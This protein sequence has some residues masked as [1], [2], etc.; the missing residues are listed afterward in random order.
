MACLLRSRTFKFHEGQQFKTLGP[1]DIC[2]AVNF[3]VPESVEMHASSLGHQFF[4][5]CFE[6]T[7]PRGWP[8]DRMFEFYGGQLS[9]TLGLLCVMSVH[10]FHGPIISRDTYNPTL[11][12]Q[13][14]KDKKMFEPT[15]ML[16]SCCFFFGYILTDHRWMP[17][18]K[19]GGNWRQMWKRT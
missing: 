19:C 5:K 14:K 11:T 9:Q 17:I 13:L 12:V 15:R 16:W 10:Y 8:W 7:N 1:L 6:P 4:G 18:A 3:R 2:T